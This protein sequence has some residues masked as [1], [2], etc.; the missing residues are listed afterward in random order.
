MRPNEARGDESGAALQYGAMSGIYG[1]GA[2]HGRSEGD[3]HPRDDADASAAECAPPMDV[4]ETAD[5]VEIVMDV[6]AVQLNEIRLV[7]SQNTLI[8]AGHKRPGPCAHQDAAFHLAERGFGRFARAVRL[9]G[10]FDGGRALATL[11]HGELRIVLP[12]LE[13]RRGR[14]ITIP[15]SKS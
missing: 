4:I 7:F 2:D 14:D 6:P 10:A 1:G 11:S 3:P 9:T 5:G 15:I 12:R 8:V 13:E